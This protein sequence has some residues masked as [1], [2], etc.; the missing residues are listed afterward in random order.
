MVAPKGHEPY[1]AE[2]EGGRPVKYDAAFIEAEAEALEKWM[3]DPV[4]IYFKRFCFDRGYSYQRLPE[5]AEVSERFSETLA[6]AREWQ[7]IRLAEGGLTNEFNGNF[8]KFVMYNACGW[9]DKMEQKISGDAV[10]PLAFILQSIDG[11]SKLVR[12]EDE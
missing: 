1:N 7:E 9:S 11:Q 2:G 8:C 12:D 3:K 4:N 10:S 6:R 5:F